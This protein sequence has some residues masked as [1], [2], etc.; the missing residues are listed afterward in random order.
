MRRFLYVLGILALFAIIAA[1]VG[2]GVMLYN[3]RMLD[4]ESKAFVDSAVP[5]IAA[6]RS[7][8]QLIERATPEL[9]ENAKPDDLRA[10]FDTLSRFGPLVEYQ[11]ATGEAAMSYIAG[12]GSKVSASYVAN[13]RFQN[14]SATFRLVL[15]K[16]NGH[17][18]IHNFKVDSWRAN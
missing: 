6:S 2:L 3:G 15:I 8:E 4:A 7:S 18:M 10:L 11:G 9:R 1:G 16:R 14:V 17:W 13:A 5:A 12:S